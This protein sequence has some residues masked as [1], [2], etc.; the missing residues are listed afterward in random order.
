MMSFMFHVYPPA[1]GGVLLVAK[2]KL[3]NCEA[4][5]GTNEDG[6]RH[7]RKNV[8]SL[9]GHRAHAPTLHR[10]SCCLSITPC[11]L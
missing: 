9:H 2:K 7:H 4:P 6:R 10:D 1:R 5:A 3:K 11:L 8:R